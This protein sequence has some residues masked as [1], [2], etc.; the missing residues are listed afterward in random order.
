MTEL[1]GGWYLYTFVDYDN[2][3]EYVYDCNPGATAYRESG[4]TDKRLDHIDKNLSDIA[5]GG[6]G[7]G[8]YASQAIQSSVST[9]GKRIEKK[10]EDEHTLTREFIARENNETHSHIDLAKEA[11]IAKIEGIDIPESILE[12]KEAKKALKIV[13][14]IDKKLS[15]YIDSELKEKDELGALARDFTRMELKD[16]KA[17]KEQMKQEKIQEA[18][19]KEKEKEQDTKELELIKSEF[20]KQEEQYKIEQKKEIEQ[21]IKAKEQE[22]AELE[23]ELKKL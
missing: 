23:K 7:G 15:G 3:K 22:V 12:E 5:S 21:E 13:T 20:D 14:S 4:V 11:T 18:A 19:D 1:G 16:R 10:I 6:G 8:G 2:Q 17:E 9:L